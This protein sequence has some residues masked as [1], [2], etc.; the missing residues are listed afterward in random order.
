MI[1]FWIAGALF[2]DAIADPHDEQSAW[3]GMKRLINWPY[4]LGQIV[5]N[6][7]FKDQP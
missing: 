4:E 6:R 7:F 2:T 1:W 5:Y 3:R